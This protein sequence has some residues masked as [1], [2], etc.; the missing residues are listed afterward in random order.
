[1]NSQHCRRQ[2]VYGMDLVQ[3]VTFVKGLTKESRGVNSESIEELIK[4][5]EQKITDM[6]EITNR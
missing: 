3:A 5:H 1:M 2:P 6:T 4:S